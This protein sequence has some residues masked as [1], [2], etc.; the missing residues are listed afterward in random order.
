MR[1]STSYRVEIVHGR[2]APGVVLPAERQLCDTLG[3]NR[4]AVREAL[5]RLAQAGLVSISQGGGTRVLDFRRTAGLDLLGRLLFGRDGRVDLHV[6][7]S[8]MEMR[9]A[10]APDIAR[11]CA[12]RRE[13][14]VVQSL[15]SITAKM[16]E[17]DQDLGE[18][19]T[20]SLDYWD[21]LVRGSKNIAYVL[22]FNTL[23]ETYERVRGALLHVMADEVKDVASYRSIAEA[24]GRRDDVSA[25]HVAAGLVEHGTHR[26]ME[27]IAALGKEAPG[28]TT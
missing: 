7:R 1:F 22:A 18:L 25:K 21:E 27:L 19:Q 15:L 26:M 12:L 2:M 3:V 5:K 16:A 8:V 23:R 24:V 9:A 13:D 11:L 28:E 6:A 4:G 17:A 10:L 20:L 14:E